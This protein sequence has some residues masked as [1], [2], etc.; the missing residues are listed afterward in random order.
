M[1]IGFVIE[2]TE[3]T[4]ISVLDTP[5]ALTGSSL[6]KSLPA[7]VVTVPPLVVEE[8]LLLPALEQAA[9]SNAT[10]AAT[11]TA[12]YADLQFIVTPGRPSNRY[13]ADAM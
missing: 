7:L 2:A 8:G 5:G 6:V 3:P 9:A 10:A 1:A 11:P 4:R 12:R 13:A